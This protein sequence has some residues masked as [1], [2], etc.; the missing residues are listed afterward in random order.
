VPGDDSDTPA[1]DGG[2]H[3]EALKFT[4]GALTAEQTGTWQS[5]SNVALDLTASGAWP[6]VAPTPTLMPTATPST[7]T[8]Y[9]PLVIK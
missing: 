9:L 7:N 2:S 6:T 1:R 5:G 3:G 8:V 4:I